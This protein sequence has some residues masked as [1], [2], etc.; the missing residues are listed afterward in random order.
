MLLCCSSQGGAG[1]S[2]RH[3][4]AAAAEGLFVLQGAASS[5]HRGPAAREVLSA[6]AL[7]RADW[8]STEHLRQQR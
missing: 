1:I 8:L 6:L 5:A 4:S 7:D 3:R 2:G